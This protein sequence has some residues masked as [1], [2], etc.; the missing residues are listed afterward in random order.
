MTQRS[1]SPQLRALGPDIRLLAVFL[2]AI[3]AYGHYCVEV[4]GRVDT[5]MLAERE[6]GEGWNLTKTQALL[7]RRGWRN[8]DGIYDA[9]GIP[10]KHRRVLDLA[11]WGNPRKHKAREFTKRE[12]SDLTGHP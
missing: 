10:E 4:Q 2:D 7:E 3:A 9:A 8:A 11:L 5:A 6:D 1:L 12:I